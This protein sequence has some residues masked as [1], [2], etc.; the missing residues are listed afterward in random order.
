MRR[1]SA[2]TRSG[3][4]D[5]SVSSVTTWLWNFK[6]SQ[7]GLRHDEVLIIAMIA[8]KR[9]PLA[10]ARQ[11]ILEFACRHI[12]RAVFSKEKFGTR[13]T[14]RRIGPCSPAL[15]KVGTAIG[16]QSVERIE[17]EARRP[18][19]SRRVRVFLPCPQRRQVE[20]DVVVNKLAEIGKARRNMPIVASVDLRFAAVA[21]DTHRIRSLVF[22]GCCQCFALR[23][24]RLG[25]IL[26]EHPSEHARVVSGQ[27]TRIRP[28]A[29]YPVTRADID[30]CHRS[31]P[32]SRPSRDR[33]PTRVGVSPEGYYN[34]REK[35]T[36]MQ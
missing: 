1:A 25:R 5:L 11:I 16:A 12:H 24:L 7:M 34:Y 27:R 8:N 31:P 15:V 28:A 2:N 9:A 18:E 22:H 3:G 32:P 20:R 6:K 10:V 26:G 36:I 30:P 14:Q 13:L 33:R 29:G 35:Y 21:I 17:I 23:V 19:V 4:V